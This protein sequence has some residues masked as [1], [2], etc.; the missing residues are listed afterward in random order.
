MSE[1]MRN[2][3]AKVHAMIA[4]RWSPRAFA[5]EKPV[6]QEKLLSVLEAARWAASCC[7]D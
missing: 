3:S 2:S 1:D 7:G 4:Q 6:E 5:A